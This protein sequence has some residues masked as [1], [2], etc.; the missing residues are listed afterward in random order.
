MSET[1]VQDHDVS[2]GV[3]ESDGKSKDEMVPLP[4]SNYV[5]THMEKW[6]QSLDFND[7]GHM[8]MGASNL[9]GRYW[10]GSLWYYTEPKPSSPASV[11]SALTGVDC[12][13][14][15]GEVLFLGDDCGKV[16]GDKMKSHVSYS[17]VSLTTH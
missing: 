9:T 12:D 2:N 15:I 6:L 14:G 11:L 8:L 16:G 7:A 17:N 13:N 5:P 3:V 10:V 1:G 4:H